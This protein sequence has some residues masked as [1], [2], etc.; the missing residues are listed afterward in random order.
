MIGSTFEVTD[1]F[2]LWLWLQRHSCRCEFHDNEATAANHQI[3]CGFFPTWLVGNE[4]G[5][6]PQHQAFLNIL[7]M[8]NSL[9]KLSIFVYY[10]MSACWM[11]DIQRQEKSLYCAHNRL[12]STNNCSNEYLVLCLSYLYTNCG[13]RVQYWFFFADT[14]WSF[15]REIWLLKYF[16]LCLIVALKLT[17]RVF[18]SLYFRHSDQMVI[19]KSF[20]SMT[21]KNP[22]TIQSGV[23]WLW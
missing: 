17:V 23:N 5:N 4:F 11:S 14:F 7:G 12:S 8:L 16:S 3:T 21:E 1:D 22:G 9:N 6:R 19:S 18:F 13:T 15:C 20:R 2:A 10:F